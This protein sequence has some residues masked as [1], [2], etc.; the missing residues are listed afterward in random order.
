MEGFLPW[1]SGGFTSNPIETGSRME[2]A[3]SSSLER[4]HVKGNGY[5]RGGKGVNT[6]NW[7]EGEGGKTEGGEENR[8][9]GEGGGGKVKEKERW[10]GGSQRGERREGATCM[11]RVPVPRWCTVEFY[12]CG[13]GSGS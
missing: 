6:R 1:E 3:V 2:S 4:L 12:L 7:G 5:E 11:R 9:R 8:G 10:G 13:D